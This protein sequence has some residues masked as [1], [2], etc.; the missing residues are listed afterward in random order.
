MLASARPPPTS[1]EEGASLVVRFG[2]ALGLAAAASMLC[3]APAAVRVSSAV[4]SGS[5]ISLR[6]WLALAA[7]A[8]GPMVAAIVV[9]RGAAEGIRAFAGPG[10]WVRAFGAGLW[11]ASLLVALTW[12]GSF[13]RA[14]THHHALAGVTY[15]FGALAMAVGLGLVC[16]RVVAIL[17]GLAPAPRSLAFGALGGFVVVALAAIAVRFG[18][19]ASHDPASA[20]AAATVVDVLAFALAGV[21]AS[22]RALGTPRFLALLG[23]PLA[24]AIVALGISTLHEPAIRQAVA[25]RAPAFAPAASLISRR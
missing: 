12:F 5:I 24:V 3:A 4:A 20:T 25:E 22:R 6:A 2:A 9:L 11:L 14:T 7:A 19:A 17:G 18:R 1:E 23:P 21:L 8:L 15:A 16:A 13:L 10:A